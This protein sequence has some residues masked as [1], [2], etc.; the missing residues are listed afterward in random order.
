ME[1]N[2]DISNQILIIDE[3]ITESINYPSL[4]KT[5]DSIIIEE[6]KGNLDSQIGSSN[7]I[8]YDNSLRS[9]SSINDVI[10]LNWNKNCFD[11]LLT[12]GNNQDQ[13]YINDFKPNFSFKG[14]SIKSH[15][16]SEVKGKNKKKPVNMK[17]NSSLF[18]NYNKGN[19]RFI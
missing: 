12:E 18:S 14:N 9:N 13:R 5:S 8:I 7:L 19:N 4:R 6:V 10:V 1:R 15:M 16:G 17:R 3:N 11:S 2:L